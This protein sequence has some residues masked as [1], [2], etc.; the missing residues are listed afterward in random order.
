MQACLTTERSRSRSPPGLMAPRAK[1]MAPSQRRSLSAYLCEGP[2]SKKA[3][4]SRLGNTPSPNRMPSDE[5]TQPDTPVKLS[6]GFEESFGTISGS[7]IQDLLISPKVAT[8]SEVSPVDFRGQGG[9]NDLPENWEEP[10]ENPSELTNMIEGCQMSDEEKQNQQE[11]L[12]STAAEELWKAEEEPL[13]QAEESEHARDTESAE[14]PDTDE[15]SNYKTGKLIHDLLLT[16]AVTPSCDPFQHGA[17]SIRPTSQIIHRHLGHTGSMVPQAKWSSPSKPLI[18]RFAQHQTESNYVPPVPKRLPM[19]V[20]VGEQIRVMK[21]ENPHE[22]PLDGSGSWQPKASPS[23]SKAK[24][25]QKQEAKASQSWESA[26]V[27]R[28]WEAAKASQS[29]EGKALDI[30]KAHERSG[31]TMPHG[32]IR[33]GSSFPTSLKDEFANAAVDASAAEP[34]KVPRGSV[35]NG[36]QMWPLDEGHLE[37]Y[38]NNTSSEEKW[39]C[40]QLRAIVLARHVVRLGTKTLCAKGLEMAVRNAVIKMGLHKPRDP[41][42][43]EG[44]YEE[45]KEQFRHLCR[46][47]RGNTCSADKVMRTRVGESACQFASDVWSR[48][49]PSDEEE[50]ESPCGKHLNLPIGQ[51][52][53]AHNDDTESYRDKERAILQTAV[54]LISGATDSSAIPGFTVCWHQNHWFCRTGNRR[55]AAFKLAQLFKPSLSTIKVQ[56]VKADAGFTEGIGVR[57]GRPKLTTQLNGEDCEGQWMFIRETGE[58]I[59][60]HT[61]AYAYGLDLL[62]LLFGD[63]AGG[64]REDMKPE[65]VEPEIV[66][67]VRKQPRAV[68]EFCSIG[69]LIPQERVAKVVGKGNIGLRLLS[70]AMKC[71]VSIHTHHTSDLHIRLEGTTEQVVNG[72]SI[73]LRR[74]CGDESI[75]SVTLLVPEEWVVCCNPQAVTQVETE[76]CIEVVIG[77]EPISDQNTGFSDRAVVLTGEL[78]K[79]K[80][81]IQ[82]LLCSIVSYYP[83]LPCLGEYMASKKRK[84]NG[85]H[86][87]RLSC[88]KSILSEFE[89]MASKKRKQN[90]N[91]GIKIKEEW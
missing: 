29:W 58:G 13:R 14:L 47:T 83:G 5:E 25:S 33:N 39:R 1:A 70:E 42:L 84:Q 54:E 91:S 55:L 26:Q 4:A 9:G 77:E 45:I 63:G 66:W 28:S 85:Q 89:Y 51:V 50:I 49:G 31:G 61:D 24:P 43:I 6:R 40:R 38:A 16:T 52:R 87:C 69:L 7:L 37:E 72:L 53:F 74:A 73:A 15:S 65:T 2:A 80:S 17:E 3:S 18:P 59:G 48:L 22:P 21:V 81:A 8:P 32:S 12:C 76:C 36:V 71:K 10:D 23:K 88:C 90:G 86:D 60:P 27:S 68:P 67:P 30:W 34:T 46:S 78:A 57:C 56:V 75:P 41:W 44:E 62:E 20:P 82:I 35:R 79:M 11:E 19:P 64:R